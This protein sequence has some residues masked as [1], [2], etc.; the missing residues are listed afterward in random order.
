MFNY[1]Y[2]QGLHI[3]KNSKLLLIDFI[4]CQLMLG[5]LKLKSVFL[6]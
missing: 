5:Y 6:G 3:T 1:Y 4:A 2:M